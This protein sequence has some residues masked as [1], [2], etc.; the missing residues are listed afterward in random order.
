VTE[1]ISN[2]RPSHTQIVSPN[3]PEKE[4]LSKKKV[5]E[6]IQRLH[7]LLSTFA[8]KNKLTKL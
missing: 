3:S 7:V 8:S 6:C 1:K 5:K 4:K 2:S